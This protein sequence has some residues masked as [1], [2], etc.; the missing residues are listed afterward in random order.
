[1]TPP[2]RQGAAGRRR[3]RAASRRLPAS[4]ILFAAGLLALC[5]ACGKK[6]PPQAPVRVM[7][8]A[9]GPVRAH[10]VGRDIWLSA[11]LTNKRTDGS[12]LSPNAV[13]RVLRLRPP[14]NLRPGVVSDRYLV[15]QFEKQATEIAALTGAALE[16]SRSDGRLHYVDHDPVPAKAPSS[17]GSPAPAPPEPAG[18]APA[19]GSNAPAGSAAAAA[20]GT[21]AGSPAAAGPTAPAASAGHAPARLLYGLQMVDGKD[22]RSPIRPPTYLEWVNPPPEPHEVR[23]EV[24]EGEVRLS[25]TP[26]T[27]G[28]PVAAGAPARYDIYRREASAPRDP[29]A[30]LN[31]KP[32]EEAHYVDRSFHYDVDY[33]YTVR[34][35]VDAPQGKCESDAE[36]PVAVRPHDVFAPLAPSGLAVSAEGGVIKVYWFPNA[37]PD[38]AGYRIYRRAEGE[39]EATRVGEVG[40]AETS[41]VDNGASPGVRYHY[42]VTAVDNATPVNESPRSEERT[43]RLAPEPAPGVKPGTKPNH[44]GRRGA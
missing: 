38:L 14:E 41:W 25:W 32:L 39:A 37:E 23:A 24:A 28:A 34:S 22:S 27:S 44:P 6:G 8:P 4:G 21:A 16:P 3:A 33:L 43:E 7:P 12:P 17:S 35:V 36:P 13:L 9:P 40:A 11:D 10:Q 30:P 29:D 15:Q 42:V 2:A 20:S 31:A 5:A 1:V 26:G 19:A 18:S